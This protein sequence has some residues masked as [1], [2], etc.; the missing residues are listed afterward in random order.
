MNTPRFFYT[1]H[2]DSMCEDHDDG[3]Y[4]ARDDN[5]S[6]ALTL[7]SNLRHM[8]NELDA[9]QDSDIRLRAERDKLKALNKDLWAVVIRLADLNP[10]AGEIGAGMLAQLVDAARQIR[11]NE[12]KN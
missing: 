9:W 8:V 1:L 4:V 10:D 7:I 6:L 11:I 5:E 12:A 3:N 2:P